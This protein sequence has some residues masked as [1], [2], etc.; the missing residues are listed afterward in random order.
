MFHF[1]KNKTAVFTVSLILGGIFAILI[2]VLLFYTIAMLI[3][4]FHSQ[5]MV[6][7]L[8]VSTILLITTF[9]IA[10]KKIHSHLKRFL[11]NKIE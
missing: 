6:V 5:W 4:N 11:E 9:V 2:S 1:L 7:D 10:T 3:G 8:L